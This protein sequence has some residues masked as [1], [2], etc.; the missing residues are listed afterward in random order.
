M[1]GKLWSLK[2]TESEKNRR[3]INLLSWV[4]IDSYLKRDADE[5]IVA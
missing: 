4:R 5:E 1:S 2:K 3:K